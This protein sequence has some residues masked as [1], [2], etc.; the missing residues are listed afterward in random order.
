M[1]CVC[2]YICKEVESYQEELSLFVY[3]TQV[4]QFKFKVAIASEILEKAIY[5]QLIGF[6]T[7]NKEYQY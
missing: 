3:V 5:L 6:Y 2:F 1:R 7:Y 4:W